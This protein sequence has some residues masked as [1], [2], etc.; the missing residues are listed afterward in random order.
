MSRGGIWFFPPSPPASCIWFLICSQLHSYRGTRKKVICKTFGW[1]KDRIIKKQQHVFVFSFV[2]IAKAQTLSEVQ[3]ASS[4][5]SESLWSGLHNQCCSVWSHLP[6]IRVSTH[7]LIPCFSVKVFINAAFVL[8]WK[9]D[10]GP[11]TSF[12]INLL[13]V[14]ATNLEKH[15]HL[16]VCHRK[17][18]TN[19]YIQRSSF[20]R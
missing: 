9:W 18:N 12:C 20:K 19:T 17:A 11:I 5:S 13:C 14:R 16:Q 10:A 8:T 4:R 6:S 15:R 3:L 7:T 2:I 1:N